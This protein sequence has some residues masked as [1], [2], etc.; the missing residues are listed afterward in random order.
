MPTL[1]QPTR[2][3]E[4]KKTKSFAKVRNPFYNSARWRK[5]RAIYI[6]Q[7]PMCEH[8]QCNRKG[9]V[10]DHIQPIRQGGEPLSWDN[11]QT[12]CHSHHNRKSGKEAKYFTN[13]KTNQGE[14]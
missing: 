14:R 6:R 8:P 3:P 4:R 7:H 10:V 13:M 11:L 9:D 12:L 2:R 5:L 1:P